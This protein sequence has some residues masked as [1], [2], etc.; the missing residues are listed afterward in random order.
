MTC[1]VAGTQEGGATAP[2][3]KDTDAQEL[4]RDGT[5][6]DRF[7]ACRLLTV[8]RT[9]A[10]VVAAAPTMM[11][12]LD[13]STF[14]TWL[15]CQIHVSMVHCRGDVT[16]TGVVLRYNPRQTALHD[17]TLHLAG[18]EHVSICGRTGGS[19]PRALILL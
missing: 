19:Q 3:S 16:Y 11:C 7:I 5:W 14:P 6:P 12:L 15:C 17:V 8:K 4:H 9:I 2:Q 18:G 10:Y 13:S 1:C